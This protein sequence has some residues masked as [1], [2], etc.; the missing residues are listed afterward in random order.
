VEAVNDLDNVLFEVSNESD[1]VSRDWQ[2]HIINYVKAIER[3]RSNHHPVGMTALFPNGRNAA[4]FESP[5]DWIAPTAEGEEELKTDPPP[6]TGAKVIISDTDHLWGIGGTP[7]WAWKSFT[8]GY[9]LA[10]M[11]PWDGRVIAT[12]ANDALRRNFGY[13]RYVAERVPLGD[14][15]PAPKLASTGFCLARD[16]RVYV[17]Y[18]PGFDEWLRP[19]RILGRLASSLIAQHIELDLTSAKGT[20]DVDWLNPSD[21]TVV[22]GAPVAGGGRKRLDAPFAGAAV[23]LVTAKR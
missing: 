11:D 19:K 17:A 1:N 15:V 2:Y 3:D 23:V 21:G 12:P 6:T 8:R 5:A 10:Y 18:I 7:G 14:M 20:F 4:L 9:N 16:G 13:I 22:G